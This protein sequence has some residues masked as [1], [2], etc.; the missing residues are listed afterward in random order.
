MG[1]VEEV[2][3]VR[4][5]H[6]VRLLAGPTRLGGWVLPTFRSPP[7][8]AG[9]D[10]TLRRRQDGSAVVAVALRGRPWSDVLSDLVEGVVVGNG[11]CAKEA[12]RCR[13][14]LWL[15]LGA[16]EGCEAA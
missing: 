8:V 1:D 10:R 2:L 4:F 16:G 15:A 7:R 11:L 12:E 6:A 13:R 5:A 14:A 9:A 3:S